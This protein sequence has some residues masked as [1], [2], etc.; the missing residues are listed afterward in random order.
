VRARNALVHYDLERATLLEGD[1]E[2]LRGGTADVEFT[3]EMADEFDPIIHITAQDVPADDLFVAALPDTPNPGAFDEAQGSAPLSPRRIVERL[4]IDGYFQTD[5]EIVRRETGEIG[6]DIS[7]AFSGGSVSPAPRDPD[8]AI[9][10]PDASGTIQMNESELR[11]NAS[12]TAMRTARDGDRRGVPSGRVRAEMTV[13]L[14]DSAEDGPKPFEATI[15]AEQA[16]LAA[17]AEDF[18]A[19]FSEETALKLDEMRDKFDPAGI[20]DTITSVRRDAG[21]PVQTVVSVSN[22]DAVEFS[23]LEGRFLLRESSGAAA[24]RIYEHDKTLDLAELRVPVIFDGEDCGDARLN[25]SIPL[26][27]MAGEPFPLDATE[28]VDLDLEGG[29]LESPLSRRIVQRWFK[30]VAREWYFRSA[31]R[32]RFAVYSNMSKDGMAGRLL[33]E[34]LT[35]F[36]GL[37]DITFNE[38]KGVVNFEKGA[39]SYQGLE[40]HAK[41]WSVYADGE[42]MTFAP[43]ETSFRTTFSIDADRM[44]EE[45][46]AAMPNAVTEAMAKI[47]L[48]IDGPARLENGKFEYVKR[49]EDERRGFAEFTGDLFVED[50]SFRAGVLID[51][52]DGSTTIRVSKSPDSP[53]PKVE[54]DLKAERLRA[55]G[56]WMTDGKAR[57]LVNDPP[58]QIHA[59]DMSA[60]CHDG[61]FS[62]TS[63]VWQAPGDPAKKTFLADMRL[64]NIQFAPALADFKQAAEEKRARERLAEMGGASMGILRPQPEVDP[65][66]NPSTRSPQPSAEAPNQEPGQAPS[67]ADTSRGVLEGAITMTGIL[68]DDETRRGSG[69]FRIADGEIIELPLIIPM[70]EVI[71]LSLPGSA[72]LDY[73][74]ADF[75]IDGD[76]IALENVSVYSELLEIFGWGTV[77]WGTLD[78]D[79][80]FFSRPTKPI[81]VI[82]PL[83][84]GI[85][86]ELVS[87]SVSGKPGSQK[88]RLAPLQG[89]TNPRD[90]IGMVR[91]GLDGWT[92]RDEKRRIKPDR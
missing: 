3:A 22:A 51:N 82:G 86:N 44:N 84:S 34:S 14:T 45:I 77:E 19:V 69:E 6:Y 32:G 75:Y 58:G 50:A 48:Q 55:M 38:V 70:L 29:R 36:R 5:V 21:G 73:A 57:V 30:G 65:R 17:R 74:T 37:R 41:E 79:L 92:I 54:M 23:A 1:F 43:G 42:W 87:I 71:N 81:P 61:R 33:P 66:D 63:K 59:L 49:G 90:R 2:G 11:I 16:D 27:V 10:V 52:C 64:A 28:S 72:E 35:F 40:G 80:R 18:V 4:G 60:N 12:G 31:P 53:G 39:G 56:L 85:R 62:G 67:Q 25:G 89:T 7:A 88:M 9:W 24:F 68:G 78:L 47:D 15:F 20:C 91:K 26:E 13:D 76:T 83:I 46:R 8:D